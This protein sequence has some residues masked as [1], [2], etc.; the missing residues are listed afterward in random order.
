[1]PDTFLDQLSYESREQIWKRGK[2]AN[3]VYIAEDKDGRTD[4]L[5]GSLQ[6]VKSVLV[7]MQ[8]E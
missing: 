5:L 8:C 7:N 2:E 1:M 3:N 6:V 4:G